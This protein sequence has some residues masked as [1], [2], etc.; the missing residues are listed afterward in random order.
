[1]NFSVLQWIVSLTILCIVLSVIIF[2]VIQIGKR[3]QEISNSLIKTT[4]TTTTKTTTTTRRPRPPK[5]IKS[6]KPTKPRRS[7]I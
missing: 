2:S 5:P 7:T 4:T 6:T 1:M 3:E